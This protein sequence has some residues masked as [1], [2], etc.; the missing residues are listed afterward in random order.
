MKMLLLFRIVLGSKSCLL[1][2]FKNFVGRYGTVFTKLR[3]SFPENEVRRDRGEVL[4]VSRSQLEISL[5][6]P[7]RDG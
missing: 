5:F 3:F 7:G 4:N 6:K 1:F 2:D